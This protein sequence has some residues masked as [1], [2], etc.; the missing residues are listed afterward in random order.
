M[1]NCQKNSLKINRKIKSIGVLSIKLS[2][3]EL[4]F[5]F[6]VIYTYSLIQTIFSKSVCYFCY[7]YTD[8]L[9]RVFKIYTDNFNEVFFK[10]DFM[11]E[12]CI[13]TYRQ[14]Q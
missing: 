3:L 7:F 14:F 13:N 6:K 4:I 9:M 5:S 2:I 11:L 12:V 10:K 1:C 8:F